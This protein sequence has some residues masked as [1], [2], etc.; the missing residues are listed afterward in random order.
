M[1]RPAMFF[2][3]ATPCRVAGI[4][5]L[6]LILTVC[7]TTAENEPMSEPLMIG[8]LGGLYLLAEPGELIVEVHKQDRQKDAAGTDLRAILLGPDRRPLDEVTIEAD[9]SARLMTHVKRTG[10]FVVNVTAAHDRYGERVWW[11]FSTN[12]PKYLIETSRGHKDARHLEPIIPAR[13]G[14]PFDLC[15]LPRHDEFTIEVAGAPG[16]DGAS[17]VGQL[18]GS[19][20]ELIA[21]LELVTEETCAVT[22][23]G[24]PRQPGQPWRLH[25]PGGAKEIQIDGVTRWERGEPLENLSLWSPKRESFFPFHDLRWALTPYTQ[26]VVVEPGEQFEAA[27]RVHNNSLLSDTLQLAIEGDALDVTLDR[28][29]IELAPDEAAT[30]TA[31]VRAPANVP[32]D[33]PLAVRIVV[34]STQHPTFETWSRLEVRMGTTRRLLSTYPS[35]TDPTN[36][37]ALSSAIHPTIRTVIRSISTRTTGP[38][39]APMMAYTD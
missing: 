36:T 6:I 31:T 20:D 30:I 32:G 2:H 26:S 15:F 18:H 10:V 33:D 12:C 19:N 29:E 22:I 14:E 13:E 25:L 9:G 27:W 5:L 39:A 11:G 16:P 1:D 4:V 24:G 35:C 23:P 8:G 7:P 17:D 38:S 37:K 21:T 28:H 3:G 34:A